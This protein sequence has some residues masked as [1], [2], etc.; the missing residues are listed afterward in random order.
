MQ[1]QI[2]RHNHKLIQDHKMSIFSRVSA[3]LSDLKKLASVAHL[4]NG[5]SIASVKS[6]LSSAK[7]IAGVAAGIAGV[8]SVAKG[9]SGAGLTSGVAPAPIVLPTVTL[10]LTPIVATWGNR[11]SPQWTSTGPV[12][13]GVLEFKWDGGDITVPGNSP[14]GT[15]SFDS[16][17][18]GA[19]SNPANNSAHLT[20]ANG[21]YVLYTMTVSSYSYAPYGLLGQAS[22]EIKLY[23]P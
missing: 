9:I 5:I 15:P 12:S 13:I 10:S 6:L 4:G 2:V 1:P 7:G 19:I 21:I 11:F 20:D 22:A 18:N 3:D 14:T 17:G 23:A 16:T 8:V